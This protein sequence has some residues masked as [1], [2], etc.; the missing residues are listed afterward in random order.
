VKTKHRVVILASAVLVATYVIF[1]IVP[2]LRH[3]AEWD[4]TVSALRGLPRDRVDAAVQAFV[5]SRKAGSNTVPA[6]AT[7]DDLVSGGYLQT[8]EVAA[9]GS[10]K[11]VVWL[12]VDDSTPAAFFIRVHLSNNRDAVEM[13]DGSIMMEPAL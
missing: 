5:S 11:V 2:T 1:C 4:R 8:N 12:G 9:F 3:R 10:K 7:F 6:T 13:R